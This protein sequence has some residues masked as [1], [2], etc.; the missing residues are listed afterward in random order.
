MTLS[1]DRRRG[2][3][4]RFDRTT[5][6]VSMLEVGEAS[7]AT[8]IEASWRE[9]DLFAV[10][11]QRYAADLHRYAFR[12]VGPDLAD[13]V[14]AETFLTAFAK[15]RS[16]DT[17]VGMAGP[18]LFGIATREIS[19]HRRIEQ[20]RYRTLVRA[21]PA[22]LPDDGLADRVATQVTAGTVYPLLSE[23]LARLR[24]G[25]RDCLLLFAWGGLSYDEV[26]AGL[27]IPVGTVRSRLNRVRRKLRA[28]L[29]GVDP[30]TVQ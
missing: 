9:P 17:T 3:H 19:R 21:G 6:I 20:A 23:A 13:D 22:E 28:A 30:M 25:D 14:V 26:A 15:R 29:G 7:D 18:W 1:P 12:R 24:P 4:D 11:Y 8:V 27:Q 10:V 5:T 2:S 16:F